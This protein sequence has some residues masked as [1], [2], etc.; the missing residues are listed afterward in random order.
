[1]PMSLILILSMLAQSPAVPAGWTV[2]TPKA[3]GFSVAMPGKP[4]VKTVVQEG[5]DGAGRGA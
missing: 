3:G 1:M 2:Y 5:K 4:T